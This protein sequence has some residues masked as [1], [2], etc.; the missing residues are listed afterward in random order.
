MALPKALDG[1]TQNANRDMYTPENLF[2]YIDGGS[3]LYISYGFKKGLA[4]KYNQEGIPEISVDIFDMGSSANA[5]GVFS[6]SRERIDHSIAPQV[7][8]EYASGLLTFWKGR[9]YISILAYPETA[10]KK[11]LVLALGQRIAGAIDEPSW[12]PPLVSQLPTE[13]LDRG[14]IRYFRHYIWL[15]SHFFIADTNILNID[16]NTQ[17]VL[18]KYKE[19]G[20]PYYVLL[21]AYPGPDKAEAAASLFSSSYL[22]EV[23]NGLKQGADGGWTGFRLAGARL[24]IVFNA[25]SAEVVQRILGSLFNDKGGKE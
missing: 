5:F 23:E 19:G 13:N 8:S 4:C 14:G 9:Y 16:E 7:E 10:E 15:N 3:E 17:A 20:S 22:P 24:G 11:N 12:L 1:W 25:P 18:G 21:V 6:H 2:T